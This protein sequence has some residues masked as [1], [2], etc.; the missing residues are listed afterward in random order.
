MESSFTHWVITHGCHLLSCSHYPTLDE[1]EAL[2]PAP[3]PCG[4]SPSLVCTAPA[5]ARNQSFLQE[6]LKRPFRWEHPPKPRSGHWCV[7]APQVPPPP[8]S[9][10]CQHSCERPPWDSC[11]DQSCDW[12]LPPSPAIPV[13]PHGALPATLLSTLRLPSPQQ[14]AWTPLSLV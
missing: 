10:L 13:Q 14:E 12:T 8:L 3:V 5:P 2:Q 4:V 9:P 7:Y 11:S 1:E 6:A